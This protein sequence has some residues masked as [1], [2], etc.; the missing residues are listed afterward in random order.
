MH[1]SFRH[2]C[3]KNYRYWASKNDLESMMVPLSHE[4]V[5]MFA[6]KMS[7]SVMVNG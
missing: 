5:P 4:R 7:D 3:K 2:D 6:V 1:H